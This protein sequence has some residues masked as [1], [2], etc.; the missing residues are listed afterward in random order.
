MKV[1]V[2][3]GTGVLGREVVGR[4]RERDHDVRVLTHRSASTPDA[5]QGDLDTPGDPGLRRAVT[6]VDTIVHCAT[7]GDVRRP[8]RDLAQTRNLLD[9]ASDQRPHIV[10]IS[11]V[12]VDRIRFGY[13]RA[14]WGCERMIAASGL[15]WT[16]Q[17]VTQFHDFILVAATALT[18]LPVALVPRRLPFQ[19][20]DVGE[21]ADRLASLAS[22]D[23][24]R[25]VPDF[26]GPEVRFLDDL[27]HTY[28]QF[29]GRHRPVLSTPVPGRAAAG[30]RAGH[31]LLGVGARRGHRTFEDY[32]RARLST[33]G[34][35][36]P[37]YAHA[38]R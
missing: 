14:K 31:H 30:F 26:G 6:G 28:L 38:G 34:T 16:T 8:W 12:G 4:L 29:S 19:P 13:Y 25:R 9:A 24:A 22:E 17:R 3:G 2:T 11:I 35:L 27:V 7:A 23:P 21:V 36:T 5:V 32:L 18:K 1:L 37:P 15:P 10:Y 33:A 20:V